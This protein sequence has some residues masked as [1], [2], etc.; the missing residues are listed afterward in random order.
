MTTRQR[1]KWGMCHQFLL[2]QDSLE[3]DFVRHAGDMNADD[4]SVTRA[5]ASGKTSFATSYRG[6]CRD[7]QCQDASCAEGVERSAQPDK[8][9]EA[10][11]EN[12]GIACEDGLDAEEA[13]DYFRVRAKTASTHFGSQ[14]VCDSAT[15]R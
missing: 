3:N 13:L 15:E 5:D 6:K 12:S 11:A 7:E 14:D 10:D 4:K 1:R 8:P 9:V 2:R